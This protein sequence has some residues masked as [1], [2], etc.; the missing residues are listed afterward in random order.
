MDALGYL[1]MEGLGVRRNYAQALTWYRR[2]AA[3]GNSKAMLNIAY[4]Y[5]HGL[6]VPQDNTTALRWYRRAAAAGNVGAA[7]ALRRLGQP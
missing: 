6:G 1:A 5:V 2:A 3:A 4:M 7:R